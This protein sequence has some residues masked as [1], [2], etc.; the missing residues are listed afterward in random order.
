MNE[1][2][3]SFSSW[4][5]D[6]EIDAA[7]I[8]SPDNVFYFTKFRCE[9]HERLLGLVVFQEADP[10]LICPEMEKDDAQKVG[11]MYEI[12][13]YRDTD[14]PWDL[15]EKKIKSRISQIQ[16][17]AVEKDHLNIARFEELTTRFPQTSFIRADEKLNE[18]RLIKDPHEIQL[19]KRA[20]EL[21][22]FAVEVGVHELAEGK[23]ELDI[24]AAIDYEIKKKG[25]GMSFDPLVLTGPNAASPH[26]VPG[27]TQIEQGHFVLMDLGVVYEGYCSD[28]TRTVAFGEISDEQRRMYEI[29]L[30]AEQRAVSM[31]KPGIRAR[32]LDEAAR[33][34]ITEAGFGDFFTHRLG[35]GL[36]ISVHE[37]PSITGTNE[38]TLE[39]GMIFTVEPGIYVPNTAG[40]RIEDDV[41]VTTENVEILT[42][43]PKT[44]Q[45]IG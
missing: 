7:F 36:G 9:P 10:L 6:R 45:M 25:A 8:S 40:I 37:Y 24:I 43:Y 14:D 13:G 5:Q 16:T 28:I 12:L 17:W 34:V 39:P 33:K 15:T 23:T 29:V 22:D 11:W 4:L 32:D 26:G 30:E 44:L 1:R 42:T 35:H 21:V 41:L 20:C 31:I 3:E 38:L 19:I 18:L 2:L 27:M